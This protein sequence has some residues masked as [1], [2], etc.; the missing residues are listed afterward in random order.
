[1]LHTFNKNQG[2]PEHTSLLRHAPSDGK[3]ETRL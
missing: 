2:G 1:M 3:P